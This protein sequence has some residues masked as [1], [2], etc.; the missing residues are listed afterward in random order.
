MLV[1]NKQVNEV[2]HVLIALIDIPKLTESV[3]NALY[4]TENIIRILKETNDEQLKTEA[5]YL[6]KR[7]LESNNHSVCVLKELLDDEFKDKMNSVD[8]TILPLYEER[9]KDI[10]ISYT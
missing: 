9:I 10:E 6:L 7:L 2:I 5:F 1:E 3:Y 4:I 8:N